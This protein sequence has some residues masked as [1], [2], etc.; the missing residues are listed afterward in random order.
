[1]SQEH[2]IVDV[3]RERL[4]D[5]PRIPHPAELA[6]SARAGT[7]TLRG[8]VGSFQQRHAAVRIATSVPGV[9]AVQDELSVDLRDRWEDDEIRGAALRSLISNA[10][11]PAERIHVTVADGWLTLNGEVKHQSESNA[12]FEAVSEIPGVG[13]ITNKITG[14]TA[15]IGG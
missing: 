10:N 12:A 3:I 5:D 11:V 14:I 1:M 2:D 7:V 8:A 6:I 15:G 9:H 4:S 13:G